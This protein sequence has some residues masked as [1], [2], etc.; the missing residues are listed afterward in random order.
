[1][2]V[3]DI[4]VLEVFGYYKYWC[5]DGIGVEVLGLEVLDV[6]GAGCGVL[7]LFTLQLAGGTCARHHLVRGNRQANTTPWSESRAQGAT[8]G[9]PKN[10]T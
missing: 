6:R 9:G 7:G 10:Q 4:G 5:V 8:L 3:E 1:M 2:D